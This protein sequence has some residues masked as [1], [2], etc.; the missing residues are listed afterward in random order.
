[1]SHRDI[2]VRLNVVCMQQCLRWLFTG[3]DWSA[4]RFRKDCRWTPKSL[5]AAALL[6]AWSDE[7]TLGERFRTVRKIAICLAGEQQQL[8]KTYQAFTKILRRWTDELVLLL[9]MALH[10]RMQQTLPQHWQ[11]AGFLV[12]GVD[13]SRIELARTRSHEQA[14]SST[15]KKQRRGK[16]RRR[17][18][19]AAKDAQKANSP[20]L[21]LTM[22]W[23]AGTGLPWEWR[24]GPADSSERAHMRDMLKGLPAGALVAADAGF[25]GY[26]GLAEILASGR[27]FLLRV[28]SNVRLLKKLGWVR[29][30]AGTVYLWPDQAAHQG[31]PPLVLRLV[32]AHNGKHPVYLVTSVR[33]AARLS[34]AQVIQLYAKRWGIELFYRHLKQTFRRRK[35]LSTSAENA[36][37]EIEWSLVG[38]WAM[39][40]YALV[41]ASGHNIPPERLSFAKLLLAFRRTL[42]DY[43]HPTERGQ[44]L[45][46]RLRQA[47]IDPYVRQNKTSRNYPRK[48]QERVPGPPVI[49]QATRTQIKRA[50]EIATTQQLR[51]T[52]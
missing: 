4:V 24:T 3:I 27:D 18:P 47:I 26:E 52:A 51:L 2:C 34:D 14:Y 37:V 11:V 25:V 38:L 49:L 35:L 6:W 41:E 8:A 43:L 7:Q 22:M 19:L 13:G 23:H 40:L 30:S 29:E 44:R 50:K 31:Q 15:R 20:Q 32:V 12:F 17:K 10:E 28:G 48:K 16:R 42:R 39:A 46:Q 45:C 5:V 21:W 33:S 9:S 1:M 36:H